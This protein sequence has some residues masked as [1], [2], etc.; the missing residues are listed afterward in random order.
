MKITTLLAQ[1]LYTNKRLDLTGIGSFILDPAAIVSSE[2]NKQRSNIIEGISFI[3]NPLQKE[4]AEL[5]AFVS[6]QS[7][8]MKALAASD[9]DSHLL[10]VQQFLNIGKP[11]TFEGIGTIVKLKTGGFDFIP[12]AI[13]SEKMKEF[14]QTEHPG[15]NNQEETGKS[16]GKNYESFL[17]TP[18]NTTAWRKP[19][20]AALLICG[21][22]LAVWG[23]YI[24]S[25]KKT[26]AIMT[27]VPED[28]KPAATILVSDSNEIKKIQENK[29][30]TIPA[31]KP[32]EQSQPTITS[33]DN[34]KYILEIAQSKRAFQRYNQL[35]T[36]QWAVKLE[37]QD[38]LQYK[39]YLLL[40]ALNADT[41]RILD[42][43][44]VMT[45]RK[46]YIEHQN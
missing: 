38:S 4:S 7:G 22:G 24:I 10:L 20:I 26:P 8:K 39:L 35:R 19:V 13:A 32:V 36:N 12:G 3:N 25:K 15:R 2:G 30:D 45:G 18:K 14:T 46:V 23:G 31:E 34:Y 27:A 5:I 43:L 21:V 16:G 28:P 41:T 11:F 17:T 9:I 44:T 42:S 37:T 1:Y 29:A 40:P 6:A 33:P